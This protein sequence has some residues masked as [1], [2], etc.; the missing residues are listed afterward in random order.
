MVGGESPPTTLRFIMGAIFSRPSQWIVLEDDCYDVGHT[1]S[2][3]C[4]Y[5]TLE[6]FAIVFM[7]AAKIYLPLYIVRPRLQA[8]P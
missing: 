6:L 8:H 1:W 2:A 4:T 7:E 3:S 5:S